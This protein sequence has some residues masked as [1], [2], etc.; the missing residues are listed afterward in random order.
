MIPRITE[1]LSICEKLGSPGVQQLVRKPKETRWS[2]SV[3][4]SVK[5]VGVEAKEEISTKGNPRSKD[6]NWKGDQPF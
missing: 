1:I 4:N 2:L 6:G 3:T 5:K